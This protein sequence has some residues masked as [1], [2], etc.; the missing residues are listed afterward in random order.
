MSDRSRYWMMT[1]NFG[2]QYWMKYDQIQPEHAPENW[3]LDDFRFLC[4]QFELGTCLHIQGYVILKVAASRQTML[5]KYCDFAT[6]ARPNGTPEQNLAYCSKHDDTTQEGTFFQ[7]GSLPKQGERTDVAEFYEYLKTG[8]TKQQLYERHP[9]YAAKFIGLV[10]EYQPL[11]ESLRERQEYLAKI[12]G[13]LP[14]LEP[15][16]A[17]AIKLLEEQDHRQYLWIW[18][19]G[20]TGKSYNIT[21]NILGKYDAFVFTGNTTYNDLAHLYG[22]QE[23]NICDIDRAI[24]KTKTVPYGFFEHLKNGRIQSGKYQGGDKYQP[25]AK[26]IVFANFMP[27]PE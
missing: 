5:R 25:H 8:P 26:L 1:I 20:K 24:S 6:W 19:S 3:Q 14:P 12:R 13:A 22:K 11:Y 23:Y 16:H 17:Y 4:Y 21:W 10:K 18:D 7:H 2:D 15:W 27:D 9:D